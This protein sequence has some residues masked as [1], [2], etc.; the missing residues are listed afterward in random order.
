LESSDF[1][2]SV[3][4]A[5]AQVQQATASQSSADASIQRAEADLAEA[6]RQLGVSERLI[7]DKLVPVDQLDANKSRVKMAEA[8]LAQSRAERERTIPPSAPAT[9]DL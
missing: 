8:A 7:A 1:V 2:A 6:R 9:A 3:A 5:Q 4:R